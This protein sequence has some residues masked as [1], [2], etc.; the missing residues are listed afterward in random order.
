MGEVAVADPALLV[1]VISDQKTVHSI[2]YRT[3][4]RA[5]GVSGAWFHT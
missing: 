3:S 4:R 2:P 1:R 5:L